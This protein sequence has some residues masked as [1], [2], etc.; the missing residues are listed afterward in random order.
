MH[1]RRLMVLGALLAMGII[2]GAVS[3]NFFSADRPSPDTNA[4]SVPTPDPMIAVDIPVPGAQISSPLQVTGR[5][6]G[7]WYFEASFPVILKGPGGVVL[8][9]VPAQAQGDWMTTDWVPFTATLVFTPPAPGSSGV[10]ILQKDNPSGEPQF[11]DSRTIP[12]VF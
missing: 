9:T 5:A 4:P 1:T 7:N 3:G 6:R 8:A 11:D 12:V 2:A 10:L